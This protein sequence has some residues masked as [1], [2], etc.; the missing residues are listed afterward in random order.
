MTPSGPQWCL[1]SS[2]SGVRQTPKVFHDI[3]IHDSMV[4]VNIISNIILQTHRFKEASKNFAAPSWRQY[5]SSCTSMP[6]YDHS[7]SMVCVQK[8]NSSSIRSTCQFALKGVCKHKHSDLSILVTISDIYKNRNRWT[9]TENY[10]L[11]HG[12]WR[13]PSVRASGLMASGN[14]L[15]T[16]SMSHI[17]LYSIILSG[18]HMLSNFILPEST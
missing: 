18:K 17:D 5:L 11:K 3:N 4:T 12:S 9:S 13:W 16:A 7:T 2:R 15:T 1:P 10:T 14:L 6:I 8:K